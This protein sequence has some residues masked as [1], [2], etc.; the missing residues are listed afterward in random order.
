MYAFAAFA[1]ITAAIGI[2][3]VIAQG[4]N[5]VVVAAIGMTS[6][7]CGTFR[8]LVVANNL[9]EAKEVWN[10]KKVKEVKFEVV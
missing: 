7:Y 8:Y 4:A 10:L 6:G 9:N 1:V 3:F 5:P 2:P